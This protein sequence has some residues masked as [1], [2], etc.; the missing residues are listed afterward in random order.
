[1]VPNSR[2]DSVPE[3]AQGFAARLSSDGLLDPEAGNEA[4]RQTLNGLNHR[5]RYVLGEYDQPP[6]P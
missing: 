2:D 1:M 4:L 3:W 6:V 5:L